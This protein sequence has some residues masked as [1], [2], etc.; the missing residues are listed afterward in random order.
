MYSIEEIEQRI[1]NDNL[2]SFEVIGRSKFTFK[3]TK[4]VLILAIAGVIMLFLPWTQNLDG[5]G[6]VTTIN[7][8]QRPQEI[9]A[10]ID[11]RIKKWF[12]NEGDLVQAGDTLL[13]LAEI[14]EY[15]LDSQLLSRNQNLVEIK[16]EAILSYEDKVDALKNMIQTLE[17]NLVVKTSQT[18]NKLESAKLKLKNIKAELI[19]EQQAF[20]VAQLQYKRAQEMKDQGIIALYEFENRQ[21]KFQEKNAKLI[22]VKNKVQEEENNVL[23]AENEIQ[24]IINS[25]NE[26]IAKAQSDLYSAKISLLNAK[27]DLVK[28]RNNLA[29]LQ[30]RSSMY[31]ITAPQNG[32]V[33][34]TINS[35]IDEIVKSSQSIMKIVPE[36]QTLAAEIFVKPIDIPLLEKGQ[37]VRLV[38]D[39]WPS[40]VFSGWPGA[41]VGTFSAEIYSID[42]NI[43]KNGKYRVLVAQKEEQQWPDQ[44]QVGSGAQAYALLSDVPIWY[45]LWRQLNGFPANFYK[46]DTEEISDGKKK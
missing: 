22:G 42:R 19:S 3:L 35:G 12:V 9:N 39:G 29:N 34:N 18:R 24:N 14:K 36:D 11:G 10:A 4:V 2:D 7:A 5:S 40:I 44:L 28:Q 45:E 41:S 16:E 30:A 21:V 15:Y 25:Y 6:V 17:T 32:F 20:D 37:E 1:E 8:S 23:I 26:K 31:F 33:S 46:K 43:S 27:N 13:Q 38:F